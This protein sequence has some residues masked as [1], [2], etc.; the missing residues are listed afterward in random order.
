MPNPENIMSVSL[1]DV[2]EAA[3]YDLTTVEDARWI[4]SKEG[5]FD[6]LIEAAEELINNEEEDDN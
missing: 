3:G 2:I 4:L 6:D 1:L 5:E